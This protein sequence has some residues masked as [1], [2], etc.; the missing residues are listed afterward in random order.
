MTQTEGTPSLGHRP[1]RALGWLTTITVL[2][3][4]V[5]VV[6]LAL[7]GHTQEAATVGVIGGA[8]SAA[9]GIRISIHI[10]R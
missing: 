1:R 8:L 7:T 2:V 3:S 6:V 10:R 4:V 5:A 9:G